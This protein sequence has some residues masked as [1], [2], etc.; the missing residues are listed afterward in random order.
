MVE[1]Q[2]GDVA[3]VDDVRKLKQ[4]HMRHEMRSTNDGY[5][6]SIYADRVGLATLSL[7]GGQG[8]QSRRN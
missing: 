5:I 2:G 7:G 3:Q 6:R 1:V 4:S 8:Y